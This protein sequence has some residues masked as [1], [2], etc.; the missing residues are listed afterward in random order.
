M[1]GSNVTRRER[2][3]QDGRKNNYPSGETRTRLT[4][5]HSTPFE[6]DAQDLKVFSSLNQLAKRLI[7]SFLKKEVFKYFSKIETLTGVVVLTT[8]VKVS[9]RTGKSTQTYNTRSI[10]S[11]P[12]K[13]YKIQIS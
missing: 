1:P 5:M 13:Q 7:V 9:E 2:R 3:R 12:E 8:P 6:E 4:L 10:R 11:A